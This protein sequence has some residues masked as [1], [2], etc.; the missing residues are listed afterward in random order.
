MQPS[1]YN[2]PPNVFRDKMI[3]LITKTH[4]NCG[5]GSKINE[6]EIMLT[7]DE[8]CAD[9]K[10][11]F[12]TISF[13]EIELAFKDGWQLQNKEFYGLN[14]KTYF[15]WIVAYLEKESRLRVKRMIQDAKDLLS[16]KPIEKSQDEI[17]EGT[18]QRC[19]DTFED[20]KKGK[21]VV[22]F[23]NT[24]YNYL[25]KKG[26]INFTVERKMQI[27]Q[28]AEIKLKGE[29]VEGRDKSTT[30]ENAIKTVTEG[31]LV[32]RCKLDALILYFSELKEI[33]E[34]LNELLNQ[35]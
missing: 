29:A 17:D 5:Q 13:A 26:L 35:N 16:T 34:D 33:D 11:K 23:G 27:K 2:F 31:K 18:N 22:D 30:I 9:I 6:A 32:S 7:I 19:I 21:P 14:N 28:T 20:Y 12:K 15:E 8:L 1:V 3:V 24:M 25:S 10:I 4:V